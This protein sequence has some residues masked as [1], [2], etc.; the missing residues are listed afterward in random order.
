MAGFSLNI[1]KDEDGNHILVLGDQD[2]ADLYPLAVF[3]SADHATAFTK[4]M[5]TQGFVS[6]KLPTQA[7]IDELLNGQ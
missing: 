7:D 6:L 5:E 1:G 3:V 2:S 4:F